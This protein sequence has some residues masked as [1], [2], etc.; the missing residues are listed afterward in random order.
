M[1]R[2]V[3]MRPAMRTRTSGDSSSAVLAPYSARIAGTVCVNSNRW[4]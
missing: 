4:P 1:R 2:S 3:I